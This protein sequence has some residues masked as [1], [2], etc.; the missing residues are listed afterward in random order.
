[1]ERRAGR[2]VLTDTSTYGTFVDGA[3]VAGETELAVGQTIRVGT[4]G[5]K[6]QVIAC[7]EHDETPAA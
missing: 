3:K 1:M 4:P 5:E 6:L 2:L 7:R